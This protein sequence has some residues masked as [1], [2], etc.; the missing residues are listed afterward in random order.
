MPDNNSFEIDGDHAGKGEGPYIGLGAGIH[1][2]L[3]AFLA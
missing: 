1:V 3:T 2:V